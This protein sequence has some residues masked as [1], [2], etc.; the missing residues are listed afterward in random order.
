MSF[1]CFSGSRPP[2]MNAL[3]IEGRPAAASGCTLHI[4]NVWVYTC[5]V[6]VCKVIVNNVYLRGLFCVNE[7]SRDYCTITL[8]VIIGVMCTY[9]EK[10]LT[11]LLKE[12]RP[13]RANRLGED[14]WASTYVTIHLK[15]EMHPPDS[16]FPSPDCSGATATQLD[17]TRKLD[18]YKIQERWCCGDEPFLFRERWEKIFEDFCNVEQKKFDPSQHD[19]SQV[20]ELYNTIKYCALH[21]RQF[22]F[23]IFEYRATTTT[24]HLW[25][26]TTL[27][28]SSKMLVILDNSARK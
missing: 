26:P 14:L 10:C 13:I 17:L 23:A 20:S 28:R 11:R 21:H 3:R 16:T 5:T 18:V 8:L 6:N 24:G 2:H 25:G 1:T 4:N 19:A 15:A 7:K 9:E 12:W 27:M 22:L